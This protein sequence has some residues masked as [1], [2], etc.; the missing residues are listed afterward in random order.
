[1][2]DRK[3]AA[4]AIEDFLR[5][6]GH[7][8]TGM[9]EGTGERVADAWA[10]DLLD[11]ES[12]DAGALLR[13]GAFEVGEGTNGLVAVRD[14]SVTTMCPHHLLPAYGTALI[15]YIPGAYLVGIGTIARVVDVCSRRLSLQEQIGTE[16][17]NLLVRE[18]GARG[19]LC[20]LSLT[21]FCMIARGE[22][23]TGARVETVAL[24]GSFA[25]ASADRDLALSLLSSSGGGR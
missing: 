14:V 17:A 16:V 2:V 13:E 20:Q 22:R 4:R 8:P 24:S 1:M 10:D 6:L 9:L 23:K 15:A 12:I 11:G 21:H 3:A 19:A 7:E 18:L 5:A 25:E